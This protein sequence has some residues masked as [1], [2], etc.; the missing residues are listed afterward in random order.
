LYFPSWIQPV[1]RLEEADYQIAIQE[2]FCKSPA[3]SQRVLEVTRDEAVLSYVDALR[4]FDRG[5]SRNRLAIHSRPT[6]KQ[7]ARV[8]VPAPAPRPARIE[9]VVRD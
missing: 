1:E 5:R 8:T 2:F 3:G 6:A 4:P 7:N 9:K